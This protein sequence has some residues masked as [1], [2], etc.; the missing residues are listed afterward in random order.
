MKISAIKALLCAG[1]L[2]C[3]MP[4]LAKSQVWVD[5]SKNKRAINVSIAT[6]FWGI[7]GNA[8]HCVDA[9]KTLEWDASW[10]L[11]SVGAIG[12]TNIEMTCKE[13]GYRLPP[14][15]YENAYTVPGTWWPWRYF[16][17]LTDREGNWRVE[18][19]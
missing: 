2:F 18:E 9:G 17:V 5:N 1:L 6:Y 12:V 16:K 4:A 15:N 3:P 14:L 11:Y 7:R 13:Q 8:S 19:Y 10:L